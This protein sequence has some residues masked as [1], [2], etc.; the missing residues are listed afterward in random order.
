MREVLKVESIFINVRPE[1]IEYN[2]KRAI[3]SNL[4]SEKV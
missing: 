4:N 2:Y 1:T 3:A